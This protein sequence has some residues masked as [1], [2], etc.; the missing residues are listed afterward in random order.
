MSVTP[1]YLKALYDQ[2]KNISAVLREEKQLPYNT[3]EVI[4]I[5][6]DLQAGSYI[7]AMR[8]PKKIDYQKNYTAEIVKTVRSICDPESVLEAGVGEATTLSGVLEG[9][10]AD[11]KGFGFDLSWSR[12]AYANRWLRSCN[13]RNAELCTGSLLHI[14]FA[15]NSIDVVYTSHSIEPNGG[16]EEQ[17]IK[18]L[19]RVS[20][21]FV[22]LLEP[23][24]EFACDEGKARMNLHGY[25]KNLKAVAESLGCEILK[26]EPFTYTANPLNPT[27]L[28]IIRKT[29]TP[30]PANP[31]ILVCPKFKTPLEA[32]DGGLFSPEALVVYPILR[33]IPCL[34]IENGIFAG[35]YKEL[36]ESV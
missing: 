29:I 21:R 32:V 28:T 2:G 7:D 26:H 5:S 1:K 25:C 17:I 22:V 9:F 35:K 33:G 15:D 18:E 3:E 24:Y 20:R 16:L 30:P 11:V 27:A 31:N 34:R 12:V 6:Y 23:G 19:L 10:G 36:L 4:E 13:I 8:D 14:P